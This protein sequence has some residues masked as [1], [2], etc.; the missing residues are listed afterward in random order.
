MSFRYEIRLSG[1]G[2]QGMILASIIFA[3]AA[4]I[5]EGKNVVQSQVYGPASRG[6]ATKAE[7]IISDEEIDYPKATSLDFLL[8]LTQEACDKY[9]KDLKEGGI[10]VVDSSRVHTVPQGN[11]TIYRVPII[12]T[13][14]EKIGKEI[15]TNIVSLGVITPLIGIVSPEMV[16]QA[17][18]DH[19]PKGTEALNR[20][21]FHAGLELGQLL[22]NARTA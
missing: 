3:E 16:E 19:V 22:K 18:N 2:G 14:R 5:Y 8:A 10:L 11:F 17:I 12:E 21:A 15:V 7:V 6:G 9:W 13:A 1:E 4:A 20:Q